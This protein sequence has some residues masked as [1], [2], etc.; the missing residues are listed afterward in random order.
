MWF[1][2]EQDYIAQIEQEKKR[3]DTIMQAVL[4]SAV[5]DRLKRSDEPIA[6]RFEN[7]TVMFA[8]IVGFTAA[9]ETFNPRRSPVLVGRIVFG[10]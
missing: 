1:D 3:T 2:K 8:D 6:D 9:A 7:V 5:I 4:P 10:V